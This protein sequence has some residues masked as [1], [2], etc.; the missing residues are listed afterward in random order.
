MPILTATA[1]PP[2]T[3]TTRA[4]CLR[5]GGQR[6]PLGAREII[7]DSTGESPLTGPR[8]RLETTTQAPALASPAEL[9]RQLPCI[10]ADDRIE[11]RNPAQR[12]H[13]A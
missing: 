8:A 1:A 13:S 3:R 2:R 5:D 4:V 7:P 9:A 10:C 6:E 11:F 12:A